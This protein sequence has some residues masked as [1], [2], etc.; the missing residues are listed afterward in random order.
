MRRKKISE[1]TIKPPHDKHKEIGG[2]MNKLR[3]I[4]ELGTLEKMGIKVN[5]DME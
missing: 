5:Q 2:L 4:E 3:K 1:S